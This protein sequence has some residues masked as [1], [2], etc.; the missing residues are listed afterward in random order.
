M[1]RYVKQWAI[2]AIVIPAVAWGLNKAAVKVAERRG[3][4]SKLAKGFSFGGR[5]LKSA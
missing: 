4:D 5:V 2:A 3:E 1:K